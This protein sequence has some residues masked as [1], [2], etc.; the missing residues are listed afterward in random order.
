MSASVKDSVDDVT[1]RLIGVSLLISHA[2]CHLGDSVTWSSAI[3]RNCGHERRWKI[4]EIRSGRPEVFTM[5]RGQ[6][7]VYR[8]IIIHVYKIRT[9]SQK[10][11][12]RVMGKFWIPADWWTS[13]YHLTCNQDEGAERFNDGEDTNQSFKSYPTVHVVQVCKKNGPKSD[14]MYPI[15][16]RS[17]FGIVTGWLSRRSP[18]H[19]AL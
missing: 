6:P 12:S 18:I 16:G 13:S 1:E 10:A 3:D 17:P 7:T 8:Y 14:N 19:L 11:M 9:K 5:A 15:S 4:K 2:I